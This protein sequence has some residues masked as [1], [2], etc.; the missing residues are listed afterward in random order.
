[1]NKLFQTQFLRPFPRRDAQLLK[2]LFQFLLG[3]IL[4]QKL[5]H[6]FA[7]LQGMQSS[8]R[9]D[10]ARRRLR[11]C[12]RIEYSD[13]RWWIRWWME[14]WWRSVGNN[15]YIGVW[16]YYVGDYNW[17]PIRWHYWSRTI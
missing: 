3:P 1:L 14:S 6:Q 7:P 16:Y 9:D 10:T 13:W 2:Y 15:K 11:F 5:Q 8:R 4:L 17:R 12:L